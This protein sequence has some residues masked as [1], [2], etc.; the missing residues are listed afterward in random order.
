[1]APALVI[2]FVALC[3]FVLPA[4]LVAGVGTAWALPT[5]S[6]TF[7]YDGRAPDDTRVR[8]RLVASSAVVDFTMDISGNDKSEATRRL[9]TQLKDRVAAARLGF[10]IKEVSPTSIEVIDR[11][12]VPILTGVGGGSSSAGFPVRLDGTDVAI[13]RGVKPGSKWGIL[14]EPTFAPEQASAGSFEGFAADSGVPQRIAA[15]LDTLHEFSGFIPTGATPAEAALL[16]YEAMLESGFPDV[17]LDD[18]VVSFLLAPPD[19]L[20]PSLP[21]IGLPELSFDGANLTLVLLFPETLEQRVGAPA[22]GWLLVLALALAALAR[23]ASRSGGEAGS[24]A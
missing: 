15:A 19:G 18:T 5:G 22:A 13:D 20:S 1:M 7:T 14:V 16:I 21:V 24:A 6:F 9:A 3:C 2:H 4:V 11:P 12:G 17:E 23:V 10:E 8:I